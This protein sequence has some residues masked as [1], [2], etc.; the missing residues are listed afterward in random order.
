MFV[1]RLRKA[2]TLPSLPSNSERVVVR[3]EHLV[4][5]EVVG[6]RPGFTDLHCVAEA[7][8][9]VVAHDVAVAFHVNAVVVGVIAVVVRVGLRPLQAALEHV[10]AQVEVALIFPGADAEPYVAD[11]HA[12]KHVGFGAGA[13]ESDAAFPVGNREPLDVYEAAV[14]LDDVAARAAAA[15]EDG[16]VLARATDHDRVGGGATRGDDELPA[17]GAGVEVDDVAGPRGIEGSLQRGR[18]LHVFR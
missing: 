8:E 15:V 9:L 14:Q 11:V 18:V 13:L 5:V 16:R 12:A 6:A 17:V 4:A 10:V 1:N 7:R 3:G 2:R